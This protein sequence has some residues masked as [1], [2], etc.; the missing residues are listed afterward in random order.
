MGRQVPQDYFCTGKS[1]FEEV[2]ILEVSL[3]GVTVTDWEEETVWWQLLGVD[4]SALVIGCPSAVDLDL[5][6]LEWMT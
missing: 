2:G 1:R 5:V 3:D 6:L 4:G